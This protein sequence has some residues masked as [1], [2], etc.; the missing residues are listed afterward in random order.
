MAQAP[1]PPSPLVAQAEAW[2]NAHA[3]FLHEIYNHWQVDGVWP[4]VDDLGRQGLREKWGFDAF[5]LAESIPLPLGQR[6]RGPEERVLLRLRALSFVPPAWPLMHDVVTAIIQCAKLYVE[7]T[8]KPEFRSAQLTELLGFDSRRATQVGELL[9]G[10]HWFFGGG[11]GLPDDGSW[12]RDLN[13]SC[14]YLTG[15]ETPEDYFRAEDTHRW[16]PKT[17]PFNPLLDGPIADE[18]PVEYAAPPEDIPAASAPAPTTHLTAPP[19]LVSGHPNE[20]AS[21]ASEPATTSATDDVPSVFISYAHADKALARAFANGLEESG[22]RVW[23]DDNELLAGDSIIE[24]IA[25]AVADIDFFCALVSDASRESKWCQQE[26]NLAMTQGLVREGAKVIPLRVGD[27]TMPDSIIDRL[28]IPLD[29]D[30]V[31]SAVERIAHDVHRHRERRR[32]LGD[33]VAT[34]ESDGANEAVVDNSPSQDK[35]ENTTSEPIRI[36]GL[37]AEGVGTPPHDGT[38]GSEHYVVPLRLTREP[39][40]LWTEQFLHYWEHPPRS[41][42]KHRPGIASVQGD[43]IILD[44]TTLDEVQRYHLATLKLVIERANSEEQR[45]TEKRQHEEE[46]RRI[47]REEHQRRIAELAN[48]LES[49]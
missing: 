12:W 22:L 13:R 37:I 16:A 17:V 39:S 1:T 26:L 21:Q 33:K 10:E 44:G 8:G 47:L 38:P 42:S 27:V 11:G 46:Q 15:V 2:G 31:S 14:R 30:N 7:S 4:E 3:K 6:E 5:E 36:V 35:D 28:Y 41:T 9:L 23:M 43:S 40:A 29:P 18:L 48:E 45:I 20:E 24:Q 34:Q 19:G 49:E 32:K 25:R